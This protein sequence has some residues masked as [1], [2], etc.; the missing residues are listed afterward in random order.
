MSL[1][2]HVYTSEAE[3][4]SLVQ[5]SRALEAAGWRWLLFAGDPPLRR[6]ASLQGSRAVGWDPA[7]DLQNAVEDALGAGSPEMLAELGHRLCAVAVEV[8]RPFRA[9][10]D[11]LSDLFEEGHE[12]HLVTRVEAAQVLYRFAVE[13]P[14]T[15]DDV[16]FMWALASAVGVLTDG[17]VEDAEEGVLLDCTEES[18]D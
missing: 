18:D 1:D 7:D 14:A 11:L 16:E 13:E 9:H 6:A 17:L 10:S 5:V 2:L 15:E 3:E 12:P 8:E 4:P